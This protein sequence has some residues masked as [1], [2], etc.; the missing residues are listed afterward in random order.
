MKKQLAATL[1]LAVATGGVILAT[2]G[3]ANAQDADS[4]LKAEIDKVEEVSTM[5]TTLV[6]A[7]TTV[8]VT[9]MGISAAI[10]VFKT[11]VLFN[12]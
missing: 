9:P 3:P 4:A 12:L 8:L 1:G 11:L 10:K 6:T 2:S 7:F 5:L